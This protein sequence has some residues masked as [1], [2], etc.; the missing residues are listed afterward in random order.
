MKGARKYDK[1]VSIQTV[2]TSPDGFGG[3]ITDAPVVIATRWAKVK[4]PSQPS[5][6][7]YQNDFGLKGDTR[8]LRF[9]FRYF[10]FDIKTQTLLYDGERWMPLVVESPDEYKVELIIVA[11]ALLDNV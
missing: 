1:R 7:Q 8:L 10:D 4:A 5:A 9:T 3:V 2:D 11:Q 6:G